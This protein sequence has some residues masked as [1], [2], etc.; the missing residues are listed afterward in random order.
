MLDPSTAPGSLPAEL[1]SNGKLLPME[2][3]DVLAH[4]LGHVASK[5]G[6]AAG[7]AEGVAISFE[8]DAEDQCGFHLSPGALKWITELGIKLDVTVLF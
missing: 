8:N 5:W 6:L 7:S 2:T 3:S 1:V 4:E